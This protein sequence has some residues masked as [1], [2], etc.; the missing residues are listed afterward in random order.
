MVVTP[1]GQGSTTT[2]YEYDD[3]NQLLSMTRGGQTTTYEYDLNGNRTSKD[4][5]TDTTEYVYDTSN[6]LVEG[7]LNETTI[8]T[9]AYDART[10]RLAKTEGGSTTLYRYDGGT[11]FQEKREGQVVTELVR[12]GGMGGGIGS[13]LY[14]DQSMRTPTAGPVEHFVYNAVGHTVALTDDAGAITQTSLYEAFGDTVVQTGTSDNTRL[15]NTKERDASLGLDND[16]FRYYDPATG[17]YMQRD[18]IGYADGMNVYVSVHNNPITGVDPV[19]LQEG[20]QD[21]PLFGQRRE[22]PSPG[23]FGILLPNT[24]RAWGTRA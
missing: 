10:R 17:R 2:T 6:R 16:G 24:A 4:D 23:L 19:G 12:A 13:V 22:P 9:A 15:R 3:L 5:G 14:T 1:S 11:N 7:Q 8:F 21:R 18:P 20:G